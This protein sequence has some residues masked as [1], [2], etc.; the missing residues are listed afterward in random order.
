MTSTLDAFHAPSTGADTFPALA[1]IIAADF[2]AGLEHETIDPSNIGSFFGKPIRGFQHALTER[3]R[4]GNLA[5]TLALITV[6]QDRAELLS[7]GAEG[8]AYLTVHPSRLFASIDDPYMLILARRRLGLPVLTDPGSL[9]CPAC[10]AAN[11]LTSTLTGGHA[12]HCAQKGGGGLRGM[13][14]TR[15]HRYLSTLKRVLASNIRDGELQMTV[16]QEPILHNVLGWTA[17]PGH[18]GTNARG[19]IAI[20]VEGGPVL[21]GDVVISH[22]LCSTTPASAT[23]AG[24]TANLAFAAKLG[25]YNKRLVFPK[26]TFFPIALET[27]GRLHPQTRKF[28]ALLVRLAVSGQFADDM[29]MTADQRRRYASKLRNI[30]TATS[31]QLARSTASAIFCLANKCRTAAARPDPLRTLLASSLGS[32]AAGGAGVV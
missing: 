32:A 15:H 29:P 7:G 25:D 23:T 8:G 28:F 3:A 9:T 20:A 27:G 18:E 2:F 11:A 26:D 19:D 1:A 14:S 16:S 6:P 10:N 17:R 13:P 22:P 21:I 5:R 4:A 24:T 31:A 30:I 12:L